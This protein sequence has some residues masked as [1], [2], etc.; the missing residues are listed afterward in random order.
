MQKEKKK[1]LTLTVSKQWF[2][3]IVSGERTV[4]YRKIKTYWMNRF[5]GH[6]KEFTHALFINRCCKDSPRVEKEIESITLGQPKRGSCPDEW[7]DTHFF[8]IKLKTENG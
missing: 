1:V 4:V 6:T 5:L 8:R 7:L 2:D 3:M